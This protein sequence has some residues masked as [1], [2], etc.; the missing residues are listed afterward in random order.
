[1]SGLPQH[2]KDKIMNRIAKF[3]KV[4]REQFVKDYEDTEK[5]KTLLEQFNLLFADKKVE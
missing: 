5:C 1:M 2:R 4:S 3:E